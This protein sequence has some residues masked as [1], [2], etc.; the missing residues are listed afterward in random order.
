MGLADKSAV[1]SGCVWAILP[2]STLRPTDYKPLSWNTGSS[3]AK[4]ETSA[5]EAR[6]VKTHNFS[7]GWL[8]TF[9]SNLEV[10]GRGGKNKAANRDLKEIIPD[11][12]R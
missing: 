6:Q 9:M 1:G 10:H 2:L 5:F 7:L 12:D 8:R 11:G 4:I 3:A